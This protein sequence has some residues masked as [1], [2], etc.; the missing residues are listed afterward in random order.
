MIRS[1]GSLPDPD[2][3]RLRQ[4]LWPH[5][6]PAEHEAEMADFLAD[7]GKYIQWILYSGDNKPVGLVEASIRTDYVNGTDSSPVAFLE[8]LYVVPENRRQGVGKRLVAAVADW[9]KASGCTELA[10]DALTEN[11]TGRFVHLALGFE[12]T[13]QVVFFRKALS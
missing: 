10:S 3:L 9:A 1:P 13:E 4:A 8:G 6:S 7:A 11:Q 2:W 12:E 5:C